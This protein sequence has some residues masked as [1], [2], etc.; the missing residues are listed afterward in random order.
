[1]LSALYVIV[2][3][4]VTR[5]DHTKTVEVGIMKFLWHGSPIPLVLQGKSARSDLMSLVITYQSGFDHVYSA[6]A[7]GSYDTYGIQL[8]R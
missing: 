3:P 7:K 8:K 1:M 2:R 5:V 6:Y 4:S